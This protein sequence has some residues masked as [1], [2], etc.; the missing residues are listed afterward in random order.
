MILRQ[1]IDT[2]VRR[3]GEKTAAE[4]QRPARGIV[5]SGNTFAAKDDLKAAGFKWD[6]ASKTWQHD[7][8]LTMKEKANMDQLMYRLKKQGVRF[9]R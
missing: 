4:A 7:G 2:S 1:Q 8:K 9:E 6:G 3:A 5:A